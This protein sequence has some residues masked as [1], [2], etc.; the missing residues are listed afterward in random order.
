MVDSSTRLMRIIFIKGIV[1]L[2]FFIIE[3]GRRVF[4][5]SSFKLIAL[6][7]LINQISN[8]KNVNNSDNCFCFDE[9]ISGL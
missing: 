9:R 3:W 7:I 6:G 4:L 2:A 1:I 8:N 5:V